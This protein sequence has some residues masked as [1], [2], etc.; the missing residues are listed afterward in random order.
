MAINSNQTDALNNMCITANT[1]G[2]GTIIASIQSALA[3]EVK[4]SHVVTADEETA[5]SVDLATG[6]TS[7][8]GFL[9]QVYRSDILLGSY[10]V[11][12][13]EGTITVAT[14]ST[15]YVVTEDD[16]INYIAY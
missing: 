13:S 3:S 2:I 6:L 14:N 4:D 5:G 11:S 12:E 8:N 9:V 1:Y 16:V 15:D 10:D 7:V